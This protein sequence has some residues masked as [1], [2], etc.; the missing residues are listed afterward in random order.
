MRIIFKG[1]RGSILLV[2]LFMMSFLS[3]LLFKTTE[4]VLL[5]NKAQIAFEHSVKLFY[6]ADAG[7]AHAQALCRQGG[8]EEQMSVF[9]WNQWVSFIEGNYFLKT[10]YPSDPHPFQRGLK[11][12]S[13]MLIEVVG[14]LGP[15]MVTRIHMLLDDP[16]SCNILA[17]WQE[18]RH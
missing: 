9:P 18:R 7:L 3:I 13:G 17:W 1:T 14:K 10:S 11:L 2:T 12:E 5:A 4:T 8:S 16:P 6:V 15:S